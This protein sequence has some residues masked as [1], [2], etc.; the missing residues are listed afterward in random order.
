MSD[1]MSRR[2]LDF[3]WL[4]LGHGTPCKASVTALTLGRLLTTSNHGNAI[5]SGRYPPVLKVL[6]AYCRTAWGAAAGKLAQAKRH[7]RE[8]DAVT[9]QSAVRS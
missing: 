5:L 9:H 4:F 8:H 7:V 6:L 2:I 1:D 3:L